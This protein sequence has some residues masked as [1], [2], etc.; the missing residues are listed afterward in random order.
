MKWAQDTFKNPDVSANTIMPVLVMDPKVQ[1]AGAA[2]TD[3][4]LQTALET[5]VNK[6]I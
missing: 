4:D 3:V 5:S 1:E 6:I 2:I